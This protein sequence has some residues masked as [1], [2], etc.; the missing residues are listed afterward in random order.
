VPHE[1]IGTS[2][3]QRRKE[4]K[5]EWKGQGRV[6]INRQQ[7]LRSVERGR[8]CVRARRGWMHGKGKTKAKKLRS[9]RDN[10]E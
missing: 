9:K 10:G 6:K 2:V 5:R 1:I 3:R 4:V 8:E 7:V